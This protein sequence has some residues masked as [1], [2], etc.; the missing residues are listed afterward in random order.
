[1]NCS[2]LMIG[3]KNK[4][5]ITFKTNERSFDIYRRKYIHDYKVCAV[6]RNM[7]GARG[8]PIESMNLFLVSNI[9]TINFYCIDTFKEEKECEIIVPLLKSNER[10]PN[11]IISMEIDPTENFL[12]VITGK[13]LI[14]GE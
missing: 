7:E 4:Y 13:N 2:L 1:M 9:D 6:E 3:T 12:A 8:L 14:M 5:G 10:E 11:E